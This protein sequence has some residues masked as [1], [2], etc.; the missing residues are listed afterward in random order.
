VRLAMMGSCL[1]GTGVALYDYADRLE[2][3]FGLKVS[4]FF[5]IRA[6]NQSSDEENFRRRFGQQSVQIIDD[7]PSSP[8]ETDPLLQ[9]RGITHLYMLKAGHRDGVY[10]T[11][12]CNLVHAVFNAFQPHG[13]RFARVSSVVPTYATE[14]GALPVPV[15]PHMVTP[16]PA[17]RSTLRQQ[18]SI[19]SSATVFGRYGGASTFD[20]KYVQQAVLELAPKMPRTYFLFAN[21]NRFCSKSAT[22]GTKMAVCTS[23]ILFLHSLRTNA[24][25]ATFIRTC[26]AMLHAR[27]DGETFGLAIAEFA[28]LGK[29]VITERPAPTP[30]QPVH[31]QELGARALYYDDDRSLRAI[32]LGYDRSAPLSDRWEAYRRYRPPEVI[33]QFRS[34]FLPEVRGLSTQRTAAAS[35]HSGF[36]WW[37]QHG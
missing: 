30:V 10:S 20:I 34:V 3:E 25:K 16:L 17:G 19:P 8:A 35:L 14:S 23:N 22:N 4:V 31:V 2:T 7:W 37:R 26:D 1:R 12:A 28:M 9:P 33:R 24:A 13:D 32:L 5:C 18:L 27:S 15:V 11:S 29:R 21:T 6:V 36:G